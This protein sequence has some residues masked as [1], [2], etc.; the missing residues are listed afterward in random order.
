[1]QTT[2]DGAI[3][4][5]DRPSQ[6]HGFAA[7]V[8]QA[9]RTHNA[10]KPAGIGKRVFRIGVATGELVMERKATGGFDVAGMTIARAVR[11]VAGSGG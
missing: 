8:Q 4:V 2:G 9:T 1:M 6:A 10:T 11:L 7:A 5:F 3:L